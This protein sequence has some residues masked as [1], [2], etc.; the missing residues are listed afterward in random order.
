VWRDGTQ[1][2]CGKPATHAYPAM[3]GGYAS[4]CA[5]H[6]PKHLNYCVT[7]EAAQRGEQPVLQEKS[8]V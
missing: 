1:I 2:E 3:G 6:A 4:L 5:E 8:H 7:I